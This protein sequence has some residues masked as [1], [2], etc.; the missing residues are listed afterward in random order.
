MLIEGRKRGGGRGGRLWVSEAARCGSS[1]LWEG[2][3]RRLD[4]ETYDW[5]CEIMIA[6]GSRAFDM[7]LRGWRT[8]VEARRRITYANLLLSRKMCH[9][10]GTAFRAFLKS[11]QLNSWVGDGKGPD[12]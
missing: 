10:R 5:R 3:W 12:A 8:T 1:G 4:E 9:L 6:G 2:M 7:S 11:R